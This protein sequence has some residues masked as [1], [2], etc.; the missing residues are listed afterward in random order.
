MCL[1]KA[2]SKC[3]HIHNPEELNTVLNNTRHDIEVQIETTEN[4]QSGLVLLQVE[5][6][7]VSYDRCNPTCGASFIPFPGWVASKK[8]VR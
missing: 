3:L 6:L 5:R 2:S 1:G 7:V 8:G 4:V